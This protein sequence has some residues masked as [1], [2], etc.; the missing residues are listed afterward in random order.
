MPWLDAFESIPPRPNALEL[1]RIG[2]RLAPHGQD[3]A[4]V[5]PHSFRAA[6][7]A[8]LAGSQ[9]RVGYGRGQRSWLLT[10]AVAPHRE[11]GRICPV[12]M[13]REY[14][15]LVACL[16]CR[17]DGRGLELAADPETVS[18][19]QERIPAG[20][21][22]VGI[23]PGGAFGPSKRWLPERFAE[24]SDRLS[25]R[26]ATCV[27]ITG[28]GE[29]AIRDAVKRAARRPLH[30]IDN[31]R[32]TLETLKATVSLLHL[33]VGNDSGPRHVAVAFGVPV[34]CIMGPTSPRYSE[35]PYERGEVVR[36]DVDCGPCQK[37][38]CR[39][40]HRCMTRIGVER[41]VEAAVRHASMPFAGP[42]PL[43]L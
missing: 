19:L 1:S 22:V 7:T 16:G 18:R 13:G 8:Y 41:V 36:V 30:M 28:P 23:A 15:D 6:L 27:L 39:T 24:V 31:D 4:V 17:D 20:Q 32:P 38:V 3:V 25:E 2:R 37:P 29:E 11:H 34:V 9:R 5:F 40:D 14:L 10:D 43:S 12:Y 21:P 26:G 33:L 35:G 42:A